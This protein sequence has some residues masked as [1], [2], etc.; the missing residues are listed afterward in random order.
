[1]NLENRVER[2][3]EFTFDY[4]LKE[5]LHLPSDESIKLLAMLALDDIEYCKNIVNVIGY[6]CS[7]VRIF[8]SKFFFIISILFAQF[9]F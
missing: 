2:R 4:Y 7:K 8:Y 6:R 1:M 5:Y 3:V 9:S